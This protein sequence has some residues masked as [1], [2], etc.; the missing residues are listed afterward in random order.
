[1]CLI[2][3]LLPMFSM[4]SF[5]EEKEKNAVLFPKVIMQKA[6]REWLFKSKIK[7]T[8]VIFIWVIVSR[9]Y[10]LLGDFI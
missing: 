3:S 9:R 2:R 4:D 6:C 7:I 1:M 8:E 10:A 5:K